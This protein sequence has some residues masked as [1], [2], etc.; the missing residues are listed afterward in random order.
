MPTS[1]R[2]LQSTQVK[3]QAQGYAAVLAETGRSLELADQA[4][5]AEL[6]HGSG[7]ILKGR[8]EE[9]RREEKTWSKG[10]VVEESW[11]QACRQRKKDKYHVSLSHTESRFLD[12]DKNVTGQQKREHSEQEGKFIEC[13]FGG[14]SDEVSVVADLGEVSSEAHSRGWLKL[15]LQM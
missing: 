8:R 14:M 6:G 9:D 11:R 10:R 7:V 13:L 2:V 1:N 15:R 12:T 4:S 3:S 5:Q